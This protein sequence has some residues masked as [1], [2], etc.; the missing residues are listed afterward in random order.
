MAKPKRTGT[1]HLPKKLAARK[2]AWHP[3]VNRLLRRLN[4]PHESIWRGQALDWLPQSTLGTSKNSKPR[5]ELYSAAYVA[6]L[7][8]ST[9]HMFREPAERALIGLGLSMDDVR[10]C[11]FCQKH[12]VATHKARI[13]CSDDC[14]EGARAPR[15]RKGSRK[16]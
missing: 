11:R 1:V 15:S 5:P 13:Y 7:A 12:F 14:K 3:A 9:G 4:D 2:A 6:A 16:K 10:V 8:G